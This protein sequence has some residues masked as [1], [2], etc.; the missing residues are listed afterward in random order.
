MSNA[1][2]N[3]STYAAVAAAQANIN[4]VKASGVI[5]KVE[6][7]EFLKLLRMAEAPLVVHATGGIFTK[8]HQYLLS[9]RGY[10]FY[11]KAGSPIP[12]SSDAGVV[13]AKQIW[14]PS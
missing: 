1:A 5:I 2:I 12:L 13:E 11:T 4:A 7:R 9:Y 3:A 14:T 6:P 8:H 10:C